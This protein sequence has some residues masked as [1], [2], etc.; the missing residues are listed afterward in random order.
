MAV[1]RGRYVEGGLRVAPAELI[2]SKGELVTIRQAVQARA[3]P[4]KKKTED[5]ALLGL[6]TALS[7]VSLSL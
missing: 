4:S 7:Y 1:R 2:D 5:G 3:L 6:G